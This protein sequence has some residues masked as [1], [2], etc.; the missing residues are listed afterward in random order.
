MHHSTAVG[1]HP[2]TIFSRIF[3]YDHYSHVPFFL[4]LS[5]STPKKWI[6]KLLEK[7]N[8][9]FYFSQI[10]KLCF[11]IFIFWNLLCTTWPSLVTSSLCF[12]NKQ[13]RITV[14][15][16]YRAAHKNLFWLHWEAPSPILVE[17][18]LAPRLYS[19][20]SGRGSPQPQEYTVLRLGGP[21]WL[22]G[23]PSGQWA[24]SLTGRVSFW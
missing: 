22:E 3:I 20:G 17:P 16:L 19:L 14:H 21:G 10:L 8:F 5:N 12:D 23:K 4:F 13:P 18:L 9:V 1:N 24:P 11:F 2:V 15:P 6:S 7:N